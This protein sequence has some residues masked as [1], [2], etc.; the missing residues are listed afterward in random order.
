MERRV[1]VCVAVA[2]VVADAAHWDE[3]TG[4]ILL[5][6]DLIANMVLYILPLD[7]AMCVFD[8]RE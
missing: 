6:N 7:G 5:D 2:V 8:I 4:I 3:A 1:I